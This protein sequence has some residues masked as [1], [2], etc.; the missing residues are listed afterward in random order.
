MLFLVKFG[1]K[2]IA[3]KAVLGEYAVCCVMLFLREKCAQI[4]VVAGHRVCP[5]NQVDGFL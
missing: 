4:Q 1:N 2:N 3:A 5:Y